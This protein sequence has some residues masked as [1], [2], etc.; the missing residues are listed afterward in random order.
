MNKCQTHKSRKQAHA[1]QY[2]SGAKKYFESS[3]TDIYKYPFCKNIHSITSPAAP[4]T[5]FA[6]RHLMRILNTST[7]HRPGRFLTVRCR[8]YCVCRFVGRR[9][10]VRLTALPDVRRGPA[11]CD[12]IPNLTSRCF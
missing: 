8:I 1:Y 10:L 12:V 11:D 7:V 9:R 4:R 3:V 5:T 2:P 6:I